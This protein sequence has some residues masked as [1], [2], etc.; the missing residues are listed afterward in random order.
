MGG[1]NI[2][3]EGTTGPSEKRRIAQEMER[4]LKERV[5][6]QILDKQANLL[7]LCPKVTSLCLEIG[8]EALAA[9]LHPN[10]SP[11]LLYFSRLAN[12]VFR[13]FLRTCYHK[14]LAPLD[15]CRI[16][17]LSIE[18]LSEDCALDGLTASAI[19]QAVLGMSH[20]QKMSLRVIRVG[21][22]AEQDGELQKPLD[23]LLGKLL[24]GATAMQRLTFNFLNAK[25]GRNCQFHLNDL[26]MNDDKDNLSTQQWKF[27]SF[28]DL[29]NLGC[30]SI[31]LLAFLSAHKG[32][33]KHLH[34][35]G[36]FIVDLDFENG[37]KDPW[38]TLFIEYKR[39][40]P[41]EKPVYARLSSL[42][43][44]KSRHE[45]PEE[46]TSELEELLGTSGADDIQSFFER[47]TNLFYD[48][49][50]DDDY[51]NDDDG[52]DTS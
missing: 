21:R 35:T 51:D 28:I 22:P 47:Q 23:K 14:T 3:E 37:C 30:H 26:I 2:S 19:D 4:L 44:G 48:E 43:C 39:S 31:S 15:H 29:E 33:L 38:T 8:M 27:L 36:C 10:E 45:I 17:D 7:S 25:P 9:L 20:I 34:L 1:V 5:G 16:T 46:T 50:I 40:H 6:P 13:A 52:S 42:G 18:D 24:R 11:R 41:V 49:D 12:F 32:T